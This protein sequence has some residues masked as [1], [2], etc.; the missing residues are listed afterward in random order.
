LSYL[1]FCTHIINTQHINNGKE[2]EI[3][4][5][6]FHYKNKHHRPEQE[7]H[8]PY[9]QLN[10]QEKWNII[11]LIYR[12]YDT[13]TRSYPAGMCSKIAQELSLSVATIRNVQQEY[14]DKRQKGSKKVPDLTPEPHGH[15]QSGFESHKDILLNDFVNTSGHYYYDEQAEKLQI[16]KTTLLTWMRELGIYNST[17][18]IKPF[19]SQ[20]HKLKRI[21][22]ILHQLEDPSAVRNYL[23]DPSNINKESVNFSFKKFNNH[24]WVDEAWFYLKHLKLDIKKLKNP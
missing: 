24:I 21:L 8:S 14:Y 13:R 20:E 7:E 23:A 9:H 6:R 16:P 10:T 5:R 17:S 15:R 3:R 12:E 19:L 18:H 11:R 4:R 2:K 1:L 22:Y